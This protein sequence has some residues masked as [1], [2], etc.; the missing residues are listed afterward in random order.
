[1]SAPNKARAGRQVFLK[2]SYSFK[3]PNVEGMW[4]NLALPG[5][6]IRHYSLTL[7]VTNHS[8]C[9]TSWK[10][11]L[12]RITDTF[13]NHIAFIDAF[14]INF[15]NFSS[16]FPIL[17]AT[18]QRDINHLPAMSHDKKK[19]LVVYGTLVMIQSSHG[20]RKDPRSW[21]GAPET[22]S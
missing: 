13:F 17:S 15:Q 9:F 1:M 19:T 8:L 6:M 3:L 5:A 10:Q 21:F 11:I 16:R 14:S 20:K 22:N 12:S 18:L 7:C 2:T 4:L